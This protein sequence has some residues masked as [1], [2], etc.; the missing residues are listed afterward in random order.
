MFINRISF[1]A[2]G[3]EKPQR[4]G[5]VG[6]LDSGMSISFQSTSASTGSRSDSKI[7]LIQHTTAS[8]QIIVQQAP[9]P[10]PPAHAAPT[11]PQRK[12]SRTD[13]NTPP[14]PI[15]NGTAPFTRS[16]EV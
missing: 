11:Q 4:R 5:S 9:P 16:T 6:S 12:M 15:G 3:T 7:R 13:E 1:S 2:V 14:L 8:G 10:P